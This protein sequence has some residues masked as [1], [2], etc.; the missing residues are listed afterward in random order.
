MESKQDPVVAGQGYIDLFKLSSRWALEE[1][2]SSSVAKADEEEPSYLNTF[3]SSGMFQMV[4]M[5]KMSVQYVGSPQHGYDVGAVQANCP[6]PTKRIA[7]YFE[8]TVKNAG[9]KGQVA[10]G[11]TTKEFNLRR[12]PG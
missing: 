4:S 5:D 7:Y 11:F 9:Q 3:N 10:I 6:A 12:Q 2:E 8:M 1:A